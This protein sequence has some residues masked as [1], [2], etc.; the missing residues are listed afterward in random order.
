MECRPSLRRTVSILDAY[1]EVSGERSK[2]VQVFSRLGVIA[3]AAATEVSMFLWA[4][5]QW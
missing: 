2:A 1:T 4:V 5:K 3:E